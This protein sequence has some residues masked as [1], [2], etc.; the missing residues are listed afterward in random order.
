MGV[1]D[2]REHRLPF[3]IDTLD[4]CPARNGDIVPDGGKTAVPDQRLRDD[5]V[6]RGHCMDPA[7]HYKQIWCC[8]RVGG[9]TL[10][11][12]SRGTQPRE[13]KGA[14]TA[15]ELSAQKSVC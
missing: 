10:R 7:V 15:E 3:E 8:V 12:H 9:R 14:R 13:R 6:F 5:R 4:G 1:D 11:T 2:A